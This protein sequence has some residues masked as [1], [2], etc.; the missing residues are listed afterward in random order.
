MVKNIVRTRIAPSP[1]GKPHFGGIYNALYNKVFAKINNGVFVWR[2]EDT[3]RK[4]YVDTFEKEQ[5]ESLKWFGLEADEDP[6]KGGPY[7]PYRQSERL[8][9]YQKYVKELIEKK[10]AYYCFCS[11]ERL[12]AVKEQ[13]IADKKQPMYDKHCLNLSASEVNERLNKGESYVV[14]MNV[15][16]DQKVICKDVIRGNIIFSTNVI[17]DQVLLKSDGYPTYHLAV[18]VDDYLMKITHVIRGHGWLPSFPKQILLYQMY[19]WEPPVFAHFPDILNMEKKGKL[20]KRDSA[21][22]IDFYRIKGF[23]PEAILN[24]LSLLGW[25]HPSG[26]EVFS[27]DEF[28]KVFRLEDMS[29]NL[30]K[31]DL[32]KLGWMNGEYL[33]NLSID[34]F[35]IEIDKW[36]KYSTGNSNNTDLVIYEKFQLFYKSLDTLKHQLFLNINKERIRVFKDLINLNK[37]FFVE[38]IH[39][40]KLLITKYKSSKDITDHLDWF[41]KELSNIQNNNWTL[42]ELKKVEVK[43]KDR[44]GEIGWK[45]LEVF[46]PIRV[47]ITKSDVSPPL[48]ESIYILGKDKSLEAINDAICVLSSK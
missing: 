38:D 30:P 31:F 35:S 23:L 17:D 45:I 24:F 2:S 8:P 22:S 4:R 42:E 3:D 48:F 5:N 11:E 39:L 44:A 40:D 37:F 25:S 29:A 26:K 46:Y 32:V 20:S 36:L 6:I 33:R 7:G 1:S 16:K 12:K 41:K 21:S 19:G 10:H 34:Q 27:Q 14:R 13:Q 47:A 28:M 43:V 9:I 18:V 15:P